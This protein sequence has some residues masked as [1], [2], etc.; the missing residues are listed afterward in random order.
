MTKKMKFEKAKKILEENIK[1]DFVDCEV[2]EAKAVKN[3]PGCFKIKLKR[4]INFIQRLLGMS[5]ILRLCEDCHD[6]YL[7]ESEAEKEGYS[8]YRVWIAYMRAKQSI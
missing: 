5:T 6:Y 4:R 2:L 1:N 3:C 8:K 7:E